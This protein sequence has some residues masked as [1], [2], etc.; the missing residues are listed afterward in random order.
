MGKLIFAFVVVV[1]AALFAVGCID[2]RKDQERS[3]LPWNNRMVGN[4]SFAAS[5]APIAIDWIDLFGQNSLFFFINR[6]LVAHKTIVTIKKNSGITGYSF[7]LPA[8][9]SN[10]L[11]PNAFMGTEGLEITVA[12]ENIEVQK[13]A[14]NFTPGGLS[15]ESSRYG[16][17]R[18]CQALSCRWEGYWH[19]NGLWTSPIKVKEINA[20]EI[21]LAKRPSDNVAAIKEIND[22]LYALG[23]KNVNI[24]SVY[25]QPVMN[26]YVAATVPRGSAQIE[27]NFFLSG[28]VAKKEIITEELGQ[29]KEFADVCVKNG[30]RN[31][32]LR[33]EPL[34]ALSWKAQE[35]QWKGSGQLAL[36][37]GVVAISLTQNSSAISST[38]T[39]P[40]K[41]EAYKNA[42]YIEKKNTLGRHLVLNTNIKGVQL[43][44][45]QKIGLQWVNCGPCMNC[46][47][48]G[49]PCNYR[50]E[51]LWAVAKYQGV[52]TEKQLAAAQKAIEEER[53]WKLTF[54]NNTVI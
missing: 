31:L 37:S 6:D 19:E 15:Y 46:Y 39:P 23:A 8:G 38:T 53:D 33:M 32:S 52:M 49:Y 5:D 47:T 27:A 11:L 26:Y 17:D 13:I 29:I 1:V 21:N 50:Y 44:P 2:Q 51:I 54:I 40:A 18:N 14:F 34:T 43:S 36:G 30:Y 9:K 24:K 20:S 7:E 25:A 3:P 10:V 4:E 16:I 12:A 22:T 28:N 48:E 42:T 35:R 45:G 41:E